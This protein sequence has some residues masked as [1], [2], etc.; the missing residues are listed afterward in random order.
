MGAAPMPTDWKSV[1]LLLN[2]RRLSEEGDSNPRKPRLQLGAVDPCAI[3]TIPFVGIAPTF[4][5][6]KP[7]VLSVELKGF[8]V[9]GRIELPSSELQSDVLPTILRDH[10]PE[11][12]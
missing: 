2:Y 9:S 11:E 10:D 12:I 6:S 7:V 4:T 1:I 3:S 8:M 5:G